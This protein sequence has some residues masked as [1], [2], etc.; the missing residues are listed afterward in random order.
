MKKKKRTLFGMEIFL[1]N[2]MSFKIRR[3]S[4]LISTLKSS[5]STMLLDFF[6]EF[7]DEILSEYITVMICNGKDQYQARDDLEAFLGDKSAEFV[8]W[9]WDHLLN[10]HRKC[11]EDIRIRVLK[12]VSVTSPEI[13][14]RERDSRSSRKLCKTH[15]HEPLREIEED[16]KIVGGSASRNEGVVY[17]K[18]P[19]QV[20]DHNEP[21]PI[22]IRYPQSSG[23]DHSFSKQ[24]GVCN[25]LGKSTALGSAI[26]YSMHA[27]IPRVSVWDRLGMPCDDVPAEGESIDL[28]AVGCH[29]LDEEVHNQRASIA[30]RLSCRA[31]SID[32]RSEGYNNLD[33]SE[34]PEDGVMRTREPHTSGDNR[35][36][37]LFREISSGPS[38]GSVPSKDKGKMEPQVKEIS[39]EFKRSNVATKDSNTTPI[40]VSKVLD[41]KQRLNQI[42][43]EMTKLRSKQ[44]ELKMD[45]KLCQVSNPSELKH[46][47]E[48]I[49]SRTIFVTNV[50]FAA[51]KEGLSLYFAKC[52]AIVN[53]II[54]IDPVTAKPKGSA[55]ITFASKESVDKAVALSGTAFLSRTIQVLR[56]TEAA[57]API[58]AGK[59]LKV[60]TLLPNGNKVTVPTKPYYSNHHLQWRREHVSSTS[61]PS[62]S[63]SD[64]SRPLLP[65]TESFSFHREENT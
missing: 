35:Q 32:G 17:V 6:A 18:K 60:P 19:E 63:A 1:T 46:P 38:I 15:R 53:V 64:R 23:S 30:S 31:S 29:K 12:E 13:S 58:H 20:L 10:C 49:D 51:T 27:D 41:M 65:V 34:N 44:V 37:R 54:L 33:E 5:I 9:L 24:P 48:D 11:D 45:G 36:K 50:H 14:D 56:K 61:E 59:S 4:P 16:E 28:H 3:E 21:I 7:T 55:Y 26:S 62:A 22:S 52:G 57:L 43:M 40:V 8:S 39:L 2:P 47:M 25:V 42:E